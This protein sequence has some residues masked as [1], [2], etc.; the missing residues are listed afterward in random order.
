MNIENR[1]LWT[2]I[3]ISMYIQFQTNR[4]VQSRCYCTKLGNLMPF[5]WDFTFA[6]GK[7]DFNQTTCHYCSTP[8]HTG[9]HSS[10]RP[11]ERKQTAAPQRAAQSPSYRHAS[12]PLHSGECW[13]RPSRLTNNRRSLEPLPSFLEM[14][15]D[16][17]AQQVAIPATMYHSGDETSRCSKKNWGDGNIFSSSQS[18]EKIWLISN[19]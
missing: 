10:A 9:H 16:K 3:C 14:M 12:E 7:R 18:T 11:S 4:K 8:A 1:H 6:S 15:L 2:Y 13:W 19:C 17:E 5:D